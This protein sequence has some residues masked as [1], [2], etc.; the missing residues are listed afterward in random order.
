[1]MSNKLQSTWIKFNEVYLCLSALLRAS[2]HHYMPLR[3]FTCHYAL[4]APLCT[5]TLGLFLS[6]FRRADPPW[7]HVH[8]A[9]IMF[10]TSKSDTS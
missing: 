6:A 9:Q 4:Y 7:K 5:T 3:I 1:M 8:N 2:M 10:I